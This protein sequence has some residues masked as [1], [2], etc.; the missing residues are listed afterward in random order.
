MTHIKLAVGELRTAKCD[1]IAPNAIEQ[2]ELAN[3]SLVE[4]TGIL[5]ETA[6]AEDTQYFY[7]LKT[8]SSGQ[9]LDPILGAFQSDIKTKNI[10]VTKIIPADLPTVSVDINKMNS[11]FQIV[12][13]NAVRYCN[14]DGTINIKVEVV[15]SRVVFSI[16]DS[17]IGI[18]EQNLPHVFNQ[19]FRTNQAISVDTEGMGVGLFMAKRIV[20]RHGGKMWAK[21]DGEN[22]GA[23]FYV[24]LPAK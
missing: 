8:V 6:K 4:L 2:I 24:S 7:R 1:Q 23:T 17:G 22:L 5:M 3:N 11:V 19:F 16:Q 10:T 13:E 20:E 12:L 18:S 21:S 14:K 15:G 9:F